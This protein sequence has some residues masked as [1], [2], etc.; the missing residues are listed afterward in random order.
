M[1][2]RIS[3]ECSRATG[4]HDN[5]ADAI[6][7]AKTMKWHYGFSGLAIQV[8]GRSDWL[9]PSMRDDRYNPAYPYTVSSAMRDIAMAERC[10]YVAI[11]HEQKILAWV[12]DVTEAPCSAPCQFEVSP[13]FS[14][15]HDDE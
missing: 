12:H 7:E 13:G 2:Y 8:R 10:A 3:D 14:G 1:K 9:T 11:A 15:I 6:L 5:L 4:E